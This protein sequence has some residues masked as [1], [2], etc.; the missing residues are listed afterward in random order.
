MVHASRGPWGGTPLATSTP[1]AHRIP[2]LGC[3]YG[4]MVTLVTP[5]APPALAAEIWGT[6]SQLHMRVD[7]D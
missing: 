3:G 5:T 1:V 6:E 2:T 4:S 7:P